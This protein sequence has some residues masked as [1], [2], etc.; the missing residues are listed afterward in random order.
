MKER[1]WTLSNGLSLL[2]ILLVVPVA[3]L[4]FSGIPHARTFAAGLIVIAALTDFLDGLIA[5]ARNETTRF[6]R[7]IDPVADKVGIGAVAV[8]L[9]VQGTLPLWFVLAAIARDLAILAVAWRL[10]RRKAAVPQSNRT[11]KWTAALLGLTVFA[12]VLD[13]LDSTG[14]LVPCLAASAAMIVLSSVSYAGRIA[15]GGG[16]IPSPTP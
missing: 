4:L 7:I 10:S 12:G 16:G 5:R 3:L 8:I 2:R 9:T 13:P 15:S 6:G 11:G 14:L 1:I